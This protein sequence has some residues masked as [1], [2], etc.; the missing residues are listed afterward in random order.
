MQKPTIFFSHSSKDK[1]RVQA[2]KDR[3]DSITGG[4]VDIFQSSDGQSIPLGRNWVHKIEEGLDQ[5][6]IMFVFVTPNSLSSNWI[7]F[8]AGYAYSRGKQVIPVGIG[9]DIGLLKPPLSLLQGFNIHS[10]DGLNNFISVINKELECHFPENF[11]SDDYNALVIGQGESYR[12]IDLKS[13][14]HNIGYTIH[15][16]YVDSKGEKHI[17]NDMELCFSKI[18]QYLD[19]SEIKHSFQIEGHNKII[20]VYGIKIEFSERTRKEDNVISFSLS[21]YN[22]EKTFQLYIQLFQNCI[23]T[24]EA[25]LWFTLKNLYS[26]LTD[27]VDIGG[28]V[29]ENPDYYRLAEGKVGSFYYKDIMF[30]IFE[31]DNTYKSTDHCGICFSTKDISYNDILSVMGSLLE[32]GIIY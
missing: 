32:N 8:E 3:M 1:S 2:V 25:Y 15:E 29:S 12:R 19:E 10:S 9:V 7:Y 4:A 20:L 17:N 26:Y 24:D 18:K 22:F 30:S 23:H 27:D 6:V 11:T 14:F 13:I 16:S 31:S 21:P 5:A 28:I